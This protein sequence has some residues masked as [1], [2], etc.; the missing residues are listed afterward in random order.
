MISVPRDN[1]AAGNEKERQHRQ[2]DE[3]EQHAGTNLDDHRWS[4][5]YVR[6]LGNNRTVLVGTDVPALRTPSQIK[7]VEIGPTWAIHTD[8]VRP[9]WFVSPEMGKTGVML[10]SASIALIADFWASLSCVQAAISASDRKQ[11]WQRSSS[12]NLQTPMHGEELFMRAT[13]RKTSP[14]AGQ[15]RKGHAFDFNQQVR[16]ANVGK[17]KDGRQRAE[18]ALANGANG[19]VILRTLDVHS[20]QRQAGQ[21]RA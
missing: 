5:L 19:L 21:R 13:G 9:T 14:L 20:H 15:P 7:N 17:G 8:F 3:H 18:P 4:V 1:S 11:P 12:S 16:P 6:R 10:R 2:Q